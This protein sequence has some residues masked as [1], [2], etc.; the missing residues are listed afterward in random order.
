MHQVVAFPSL[1]GGKLET[2]GYVT[3]QS[4][5]VN[6]EWGMNVTSGP[7]GTNEP[8]LQGRGLQGLSTSGPLT[9]CYV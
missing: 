7:P 1:A 6:V 3:W 8:L 5:M 4:R 9:R 2:L